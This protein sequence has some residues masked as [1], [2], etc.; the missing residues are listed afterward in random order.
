MAFSITKRSGAARVL[1]AVVALALAPLA[2]AG[3]RMGPLPSGAIARSVAG[4]SDELVGYLAFDPRLVA[5]KLPRGARFATLQDKA[6]HW[7]SLAAYLEHHPERRDWAWSYYEIIL[8]RAARYDRVAGRFGDGGGMAVWYAE[9]APV[10]AADPRPHGEQSLALGS[11][12]S[13]PK[14]V[15]Y[16]RGRGFPADDAAIAFHRDHD[17]ARATM[18]RADLTIEGRCRLE[19]LAFVPDWAREPLSY[20]TFWTPGDAGTFEVVTWTGHQSI[21]CA[22]PQWTVSGDHPF[23]KAFNDP[24]LG[25]PAI[26]PTDFNFGYSLRSGLYRRKS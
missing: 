23:A 3:E 26:Y 19:G 20:Q 5:D 8:L 11:W 25:D 12:L 15:A 13:D 24:A 21:K 1:L 16:M 7:K 22:D 9:L 18:T 2:H 14:L 10:D 4:P 17:T 6:A